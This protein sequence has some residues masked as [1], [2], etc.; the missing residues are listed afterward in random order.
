[1]DASNHRTRDLAA[2]P[3]AAVVC[4]SCHGP[5]DAA[6]LFCG[7]CGAIQ[8]PGQQ[9]HFSRLGV[10]PCFD[11]DLRALE[12]RYFRAQ[13][14]LH[15]DRFATRSPRERALSQQQATTLNAAYEV[16]KDPLKRADYLLQ[17]AGWNIS[18]AGCDLVNDQTLLMEALQ[19]REALAEA[20]TPQDVQKLEKGTRGDVSAC[21]DELSAAF[22]AGD[23]DR[24]SRLTTRLKYLNKLLSDC[25][26][27]RRQITGDV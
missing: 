10:S 7:T 6:A 19:M 1:M 8:P 25:R 22:S 20:E 4:W 3:E 12:Q 16:L 24:A 26:T 17:R 2:P 11:V 27:R 5:V 9:D 21:V 23:F 13:A 15:P 18:T 14:Q